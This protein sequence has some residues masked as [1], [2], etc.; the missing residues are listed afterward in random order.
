MSVTQDVQ[1]Q[2]VVSDSVMLVVATLCS[3]PFLFGYKCH[4]SFFVMT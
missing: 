4:F 3:F 1:M 2:V